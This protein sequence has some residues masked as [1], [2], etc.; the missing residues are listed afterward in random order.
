MGSV[1]TDNKVLGW[2]WSKKILGWFLGSRA[3][4]VLSLELQKL[5]GSSDHQLLQEEGGSL[6]CQIR[7]GVG[8]CQYRFWNWRS[9]A[10]VALALQARI[11][12]A[13]FW[14]GILVGWKEGWQIPYLGPF[15]AI[16]RACCVGLRGAM[17]GSSWA[18]WSCPGTMSRPWFRARG[19]QIVINQ[20]GE[21]QTWYF[22]RLCL[23]C[24]TRSQ[25][26][27]ISYQWRERTSDMFGCGGSCLR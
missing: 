6:V 23:K 27:L 21:A 25:N 24:L 22:E 14:P 8:I 10:L 7:D 4:I 26:W 9:F 18:I 20:D 11:F 19:N 13:C 12:L 3:W 16:L 5:S 17:L 2:Y 1:S 15:G